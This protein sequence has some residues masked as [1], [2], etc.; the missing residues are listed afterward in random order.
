MACCDPPMELVRCASRIGHPE[1]RLM[2]KFASKYDAGDLLSDSG[3]ASKIGTAFFEARSEIP[4]RSLEVATPEAQDLRRALLKNATIVFVTAGYPGKRHIFEHAAKLGIKSVIVDHPQSWSRELLAEGIIAKYIPLDVSAPGEEVFESALASIKQLGADGITGK[5]DAITTFACLSV[6]LSARLCEAL[7]L[8]GPLRESVEKARDKYKSRLALQQ[9]GLPTPKTAVVRTEVEVLQASK[10]IGFPAV[11][12]PTSGAGS[13]CVKKVE[14]EQDL[15]SSFREVVEE[16]NSLVISSGALA[17][18]TG[19]ADSV[20][21]NSVVDLSMLLEQY[22]DGEEVDVDVI[23]SDGEVRFASVTY[24][25]PTEEPYFFEPWA[26]CPAVFL[27]KEQQE[28]L[29]QFSSD[30]LK[31]MGFTAGVF[32][33]ECRY[34]SNGPQLIE[35]NV[36]MGGG[37]VR[38][39]ML[40]CWGI[41]YAEETLICAL[42]L[43]SRPVVPYSP[44]IC[45]S[46][47]TLLCKKSGK[48]GTI[49]PILALQGQPG[50]FSVEA[51]VSVGDEVVANSSMLG[52]VI[53]TD[54][55]A[56]KSRD[57]ALELEVGLDMEIE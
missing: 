27:P 12:K 7:G 53:V 5:V 26:T 42:G 52:Y 10:T 4:R 33:V 51:L 54:V 55:D 28:E 39:L 23:M 3:D 25:A 32:H 2:D 17:R 38:H 21:A 20:Q 35:V 56:E 37:P 50:V 47:T 40:L 45:A 18:N 15:I 1:H 44:R 36:R 49:S 29:K 19:L 41:D 8:P 48:I 11:L 46:Y 43:P 24:N 22:I 6:P 30:C 9:A 31:A 57:R 34:S 14:Y 16:S 13:F